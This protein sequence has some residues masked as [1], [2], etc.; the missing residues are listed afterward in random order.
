MQLLPLKMLTFFALTA[1]AASGILGLWSAASILSADQ[2]TSP[3]DIDVL[4]SLLIHGAF[5]N[6]FV[7]SSI[8]FGL[9]GFLGVAIAIALKSIE[10][11]LITANSK[12]GS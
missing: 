6:S 2:Q 4:Q 12:P 3:P 11:R 8:T 9:I 5:T 1:S 10:R 7:L